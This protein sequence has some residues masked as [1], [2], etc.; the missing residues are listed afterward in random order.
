MPSAT[1]PSDPTSPLPRNHSQ[2]CRA[3]VRQVASP[4]RSARAAL[5]WMYR[6]LEMAAWY[7]RPSFHWMPPPQSPVQKVCMWSAPA[8]A[9]AR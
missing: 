7:V 6:L 4:V 2:P 8:F 5:T 3:R 9:V 1:R